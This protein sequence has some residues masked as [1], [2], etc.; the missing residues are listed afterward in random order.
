MSVG[1]FVSQVRAFSCSVDKAR[2]QGAYNNGLAYAESL[3]DQCA[4]TFLPELPICR[5]MQVEG[6]ITARGLD[7][8]KTVKRRMGFVLQVRN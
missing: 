5:S 4:I 7:L 3:L 6:S 2:W 8:I 1:H